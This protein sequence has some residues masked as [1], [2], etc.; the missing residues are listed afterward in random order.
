MEIVNIF[1]VMCCI[2]GSSVCVALAQ[3]SMVFSLSLELVMKYNVL[4]SLP[5]LSRK[6]KQ[7]EILLS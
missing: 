4:V 5:F 1:P 6:M 2:L 7:A 3:I